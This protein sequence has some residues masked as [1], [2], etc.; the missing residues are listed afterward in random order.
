MHG[1]LCRRATVGQG[2]EALSSYEI[3]GLPI[4]ID[5]HLDSHENL[6]MST[7]TS[8]PPTQEAA[9]ARAV[10]DH[11]FKGKPVDPEVARRVH[12]RA[13]TIREEMR[14]GPVTDFA[15]DILH[16]SRDE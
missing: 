1:P 9:D 10:L 5:S 15:I 7:D 11:A 8:K 2:G 12:E 3:P 14:K 13:K 6:F 16:E 4:A